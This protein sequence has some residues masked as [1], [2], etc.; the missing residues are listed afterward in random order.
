MEDTGFSM[1]ARESRAGG[2][3]GG[4]VISLLETESASLSGA[5]VS[6]ERGRF[7]GSSSEEDSASKAEYGVSSVAAESG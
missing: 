4:A 3:E 7:L 1:V 2:A 5:G 6:G